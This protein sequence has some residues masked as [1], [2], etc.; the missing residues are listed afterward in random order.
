[1]FPGNKVRQFKF[2]GRLTLRSPC[3]H[4]RV[5]QLGCGREIQ[6]FSGTAAPLS[7]RLRFILTA[8]GTN[9]PLNTL[10]ERLHRAAPPSPPPGAPWTAPPWHTFLGL[11]H[12]RVK[13]DGAKTISVD[14]L[15]I[16]LRS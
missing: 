1:M 6:A 7:P 4:L 14:L 8:A 16:P 9:P 12:C 3:S 5:T 10:P 13:Y 11:G 2:P 15:S